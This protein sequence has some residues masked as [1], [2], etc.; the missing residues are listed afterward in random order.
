M[1]YLAGVVAALLFWLICSVMSGFY[2]P[3]K[4]I[5]G[6]DS[7]AS[8]SKVQWFLWTAVIA[9]SYVTLYTARARAGNFTPIE[10][11]P[12]NVW[13]LMGLSTGTMIAAK[14]ATVAYARRGRIIKTKSTGAKATDLVKDDSGF[15]DLSKAQLL[16]WTLIAIGIYIASVVNQVGMGE[17]ALMPDIGPTLMVL[18]GLSEGAYLGKKLT[19][20]TAPRVNGLI[21]GAGP[22]GTRIRIT[23]FQFGNNQNGSL[24]AL[25]GNPVATEIPDNDW[26]DSQIAF[27]LPEVDLAG[28]NERRVMI[29]VIVNGQESNAMPFTVTSSNK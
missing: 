17:S 27:A 16:T 9:F 28:L 2:N 15:P 14:G 23:G 13:I 5:E 1:E 4:L 24:V 11:L 19:T 21:P 18:T 10:N 25:D 29:S 12:Y 26:K 7:R 3:L 22:S 6:Q 20:T 8:I